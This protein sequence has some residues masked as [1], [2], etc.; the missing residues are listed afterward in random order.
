MKYLT[1][2]S[3]REL[4][5]DFS[6][7]L[8]TA[9]GGLLLI[10]RPPIFG[11]ILLGDDLQVWEGHIGGTFASSIQESL[12]NASLD[13]WRPLNT[14]AMITILKMFETSYRSYYW[15]S[16][17]LIGAL[18]VAV[19]VGARSLLGTQSNRESKV[20]TYLLVL[21]IGSSPFTYFGRSGVF[22]FLEFMPLI[23]CVS[24]FAIYQRAKILHSPLL[25]AYS[26]LVALA[27]GLVHERYLAY[28]A[29]MMLLVA[30]HARR[31]PRFRGLWLTYF[32]NVVFYVYSAGVVLNAN[33][34]KGGGEA[35]LNESA[36]VWIL[37]RIF[38]AVLHL[39]GGAGGESV[40]FDPFRPTAFSPGMTFGQNYS[41]LFPIAIGCLVLLM[42]VGVVRETIRRT[43][44]P[45]KHHAWPN[46]RVE[47][48]LIA[49]ALLLPGATV[50]QR[51]EARW[52]FGSLVFFCLLLSAFS[53]AKTRLVRWTA[54]STLSLI[55]VGNV[56]HRDSF[57]EYDW[58]RART[59]PVLDVV[60]KE[61]PA[62]G[63]WNIAITWPDHMDV[64][65][66]L[67]WSLGNGSALR[68]LDN[69]PQTILFGV[70]DELPV[71]PAP[72]LYVTV[73]DTG[74]RF[75]DFR[76]TEFQTITTAWRN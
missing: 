20:A 50:V 54:M 23:L 35:N 2:H 37:R 49:I 60:R 53:A 39:A 44:G 19:F 15:F 46:L 18:L 36:G 59:K 8:S 52:L 70:I 65:S 58:W 57:S 45:P 25:V 56:Y 10:N 62:A 29:M 27:G 63:D 67:A 41:L 51:I 69:G 76:K 71:C 30:W 11:D 4:A 7:F 24:S 5:V 64:H 38:F 66:G 32:G 61:E 75:R 9:I 40:Y 33:T 47:V 28:S 34:L 1:K 12:R 21:A 72:C 48:L 26:A 3:I 31:E 14:T 13:K 68:T 73:T 55:I 6:L 42:L 22:G 17:V 16:T 43:E 74:N